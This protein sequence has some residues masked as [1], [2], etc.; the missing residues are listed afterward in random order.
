MVWHHRIRCTFVV[1]AL[2][3]TLCIPAAT[4]QGAIFNVNTAA[5]PVGG[6]C[7]A[8]CSLRQAITAA[9]S[10]PTADTIN[11]PAGTYT[12]TGA[13]G[14]D[15]NLSGDLDM[16]DIGT[17]STTISGAGARSTRIVGTGA[18]RV[19]NLSDS[20]ETISISGVTIT[21]GAA[22]D[23]G[24][25]GGIL[26]DGTF[27]L[28]NA[29]V[30]GNRVQGDNVSSNQG[31]G[32]F[33]ANHIN[34]RNV[35][36]SGNIAARGTT[37]TFGPQGGGLFD[38]GAVPATLTNVTISGNQA[39]GAGSQGGGMFYNAN[40][41]TETLTNVTISGNHADGT[42][43]D[44]GG[45]FI[46]D[47]LTVRNTIIAGNTVN[48]GKSDCSDSGGN[49]VTSSHNLEG[50]TGCL[51]NG[52]G[53]L[54]NANPLLGALRNNGG[55]TDTQALGSGSP[56]IDAGLGC[57]A[58]D[59]RGV[60]RPLGPACDIGAFEAAAAPPAG[61]PAPVL[62]K[63]FNAVPLSGKVFIS[64]PAGA[65][66]ASASVPGLKGRTFVP[67]VTARQVPVGSILDTRKGK[68]RLTTAST[69]A[70][71]TFT[72]DFGSGVFQVLQSG[73]AKAKGL[74]ELRLKGASFKSCKRGKKRAAG[75][76]RSKRTVRRL[77]SKVSGRF[78]TRGRY[79]AAT[80]RGTEWLTADRCDGT[81]TKVNRGKVAVRDFRRH[82][83]IVLRKGK[84][85][86]AKAPR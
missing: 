79:S 35:T 61:I 13:A 6:L 82:K 33:S 44:G 37:N 73:K 56:A 66:R 86:L 27:N 69:D 54:R 34:M 81:L 83:T 15:A 16:N 46:N 25:G 67:L 57:P 28:T 4:A 85:Y 45:L 19:I 11:L 2:A 18:D 32:I 20:S 60:G 14:D 40:A 52:P 80:V 47:S 39:T 5:D 70:G 75:T 68:V 29:A 41:N 48:G 7:A 58:T 24:V 42:G 77:R 43:A 22:I 36:I 38:N 62:G 64:L 78:R 55:Q 10:A 72:G 12:L 17:A 49:V 50:G 74:T 53:D 9:N 1:C 63:R 21:G 23:G 76:S 26:A 71:K 51:F 3:G 8:T 65:A 59:Q 84:S 31:G 30:V